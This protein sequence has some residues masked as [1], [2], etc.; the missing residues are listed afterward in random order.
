MVK[1]QVYYT[2]HETQQTEKGVIEDK[3][4]VYDPGLECAVDVYLIRKFSQGNIEEVSPLKVI[5]IIGY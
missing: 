5:S 3:V 1:K 2:S 4:R